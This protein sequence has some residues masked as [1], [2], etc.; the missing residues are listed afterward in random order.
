[1]MLANVLAEKAKARRH[2][3]DFDRKGKKADISKT[4]TEKAKR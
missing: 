2:L 4:L 1:M 3:K